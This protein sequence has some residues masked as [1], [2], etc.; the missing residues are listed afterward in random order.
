MANYIPYTHNKYYESNKLGSDETIIHIRHAR[1][2]NLLT[3]GLTL[4]ETASDQFDSNIAKLDEYAQLTAEMNEKY[5]QLNSS[6]TAITTHPQY[7]KKININQPR[8]LADDMQHD[9]KLDLEVN[10]NMMILGSITMATLLV[11]LTVA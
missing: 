10:R 1:N 6:I 11:Y 8:N 7:N 5:R 2:P 4:V 9:N 3:E